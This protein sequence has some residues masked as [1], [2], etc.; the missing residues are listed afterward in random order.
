MLEYPSSAPQAGW[1]GRHTAFVAHSPAVMTILTYLII[2]TL[3]ARLPSLFTPAP[4]PTTAPTP[5]TPATGPPSTNL[6]NPRSPHTGS[7]CTP[8][9]ALPPTAPSG[10][11]PTPF[12]PNALVIPNAACMSG[13]TSSSSSGFSG[14]RCGGR[15]ISSNGRKWP[16][17]R[18]VLGSPVGEVGPLLEFEGPL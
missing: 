8:A 3:P 4:V 12:C 2:A 6:S 17:R 7:L 10:P 14:I 16:G 5:P 18:V 9:P 15:W 1:R 11:P 13:T